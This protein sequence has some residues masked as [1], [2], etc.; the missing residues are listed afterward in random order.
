[1]KVQKY[2]ISSKYLVIFGLE[3]IGVLFGT[4]M[5]VREERVTLEGALL[6][7]LASAIFFCVNLYY[8]RS[9]WLIDLEKYRFSFPEKFSKRASGVVTDH[10]L[11]KR[12]RV[13]VHS[14]NSVTYLKEYVTKLVTDY[15]SLGDLLAAFKG[16]YNH[17]AY[18]EPISFRDYLGIVLKPVAFKSSEE[19]YLL[20]S[21]LMYLDSLENS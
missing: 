12:L 7:L 15:W 17:S 20:I 13:T 14:E 21:C 5:F 1:M 19:A 18:A 10:Y 3:I 9:Y 6:F 4:Y 11:Y 16:G 8:V 2:Y